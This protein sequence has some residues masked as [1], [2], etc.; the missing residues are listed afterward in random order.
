MSGDEVA[1][2]S[3]IRSND[4]HMNEQGLALVDAFPRTCIRKHLGNAGPDELV[5]IRI[6]GYDV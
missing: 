1:C 2:F 6:A 3:F 4:Q 5:G